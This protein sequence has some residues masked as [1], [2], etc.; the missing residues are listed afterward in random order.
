MSWRCGTFV[1]TLVLDG[2]KQEVP[3][4]DRAICQDC[5]HAH[6]GKSKVAKHFSVWSLTS[7]SLKTNADKRVFFTTKSAMTG[8]YRVTFFHRAETQGVK[9]LLRRQV[10]CA[11][12]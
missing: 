7:S 3:V 4:A 1:W 9:L 8:W 10:L 12:L 2:E 11:R 5:L 6:Y